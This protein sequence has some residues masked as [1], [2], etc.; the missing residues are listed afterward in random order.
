MVIWLPTVGV[1]VDSVTE[2]CKPPAAVP[3]GGAL[4]EV[5]GK[6]GILG[7]PADTDAL[8]AAILRV[9]DN[10]DEAYRLGLAGYNRVRRHFTW[11]NAAETCVAAYREAIRDYR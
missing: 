8:A 10:P 1:V 5:V 11:R 2:S 3:S 9:L 6:A 4:P 7:P